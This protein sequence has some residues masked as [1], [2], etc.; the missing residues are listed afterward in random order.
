MKTTLAN[1]RRVLALDVRPQRAGYAV[2]EGPNVLL[3]VGLTVFKTR[4]DAKRRLTFLV[5]IY[6]PDVIVTRK[7]RHRSR[8]D[9]LETRFILHKAHRLAERTSATIAQIRETELRKYFGKFGAYTKH[10][11][12]SFVAHKFPDL[13][14]RLPPPRRVWQSERARMSIFDAVSC[15]VAYFS[16]PETIRKRIKK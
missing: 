9:H 7:L 8:R 5:D 12:A 15:G 13:A 6:R 16:L 14:Y 3:D 10:Q 2:F 4:P 1:G 11:I